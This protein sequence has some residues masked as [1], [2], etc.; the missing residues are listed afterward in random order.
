[1]DVIY[2]FTRIKNYT[3]MKKVLIQAFSTLFFIGILSGCIYENKYE[4]AIET[5]V[6]KQEN[7]ISL[8][9]STTVHPLMKKLAESFA[10]N[11]NN[12]QLKITSSGSM[13]GI[14][15]LLRDSTDIAM[16]SNKISPEIKAA[17][18]KINKH[19]VEY[20]IAG[21]ALVF[22]VNVN[23]PVK[24]LTLKQVVDIFTGKVTNWKQVG[25]ENMPITLIS[26]DYKSGTYLF[27]MED[28]LTKDSLSK[29]AHIELNNENVLKSIAKDKGA[30]GY[31]NFSML[32]YSVDP[33]SISFDNTTNHV[34]PRMETVNN[35]TY[36]YFRGLYLYYNPEKYQ[37]I[38]PLLDFIHADST[39]HLIEKAGYIPVNQKLIVD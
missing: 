9:G 4:S 17:F 32:D 5:P 3:F 27:F 37:K 1:M 13:N 24:K 2:T 6:H 10:L 26:R 31:T 33:V 14:K 28:V 38:K 22:A 18:R 30:I 25:G 19:Y 36:K 34:A 21:D 23:N 11:E 29:A 20:L 15:N 35:M 16:A 39:K 7:F 8:K 12:P